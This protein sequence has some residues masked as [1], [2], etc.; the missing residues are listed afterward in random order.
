[1]RE[2]DII[3]ELLRIHGYDNVEIPSQIRA[4]LNY[5]V[6]PDKEAVRNQVASLLSA[7]GFFEILSNSLTK[8][9]YSPDP[10]KAIRILN[11]LSSDLDVM[12]QDMLYS[13][14]EAIAHN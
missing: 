3:E 14:L 9:S 8:I 5:T 1:N 11:P 6:K 2:V 7:N 13:G 4:S 10:E 12:R